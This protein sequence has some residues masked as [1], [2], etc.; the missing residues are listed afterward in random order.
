MVYFDIDRSQSLESVFD[1]VSCA[2]PPTIFLEDDNVPMIVDEF[3][4]CFLY[5]SFRVSEVGDVGLLPSS[6][7]CVV[8]IGGAG[9]MFWEVWSTSGSD[10]SVVL[11][12]E[13]VV[14]GCQGV[15]TSVVSILGILA[16]S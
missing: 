12:R 7:R 14:E 3:D 5:V 4:G 16:L 13:V 1:L 9:D 15:V 8:P 6:G 10:G 11:G 2:R